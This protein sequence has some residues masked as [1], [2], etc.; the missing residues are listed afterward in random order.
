[1][2]DAE[3]RQRIIDAFV[4]A[5]YL[6]DDKVVLYYNIKDSKQASYIDMLS[7]LEETS[8]ENEKEE[9][10]SSDCSSNVGILNPLAEREGFEPSER[11]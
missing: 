8:E 3:F 10:S 7:D 1:M 6:F 9:Q 5:V 4:N 11:Y 2:F